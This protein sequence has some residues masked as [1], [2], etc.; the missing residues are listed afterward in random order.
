MPRN[1][2]VSGLKQEEAE[3]LERGR[4]MLEKELH[5]LGMS[6]ISRDDIA[7]LFKY[8]DVNSFCIAI[9]YGEISPNRIG[10]TLAARQEQPRIKEFSPESKRESSSVQVLGVGDLLTKL[11]NCCNPLPGDE[12]IGY[13]TRNRGITVH[14]KDCPNVSKTRE[15]DRLISVEWGEAHQTYPV[16]IRLEASDRVG[17]LRDVSTTI[18]EESVNIIG[19]GLS[20]KDNYD[21]NTVMFITLE[22]RGIT[23]LERVMSKLEGVKGV[24]SVGRS[25]G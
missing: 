11:S 6:S 23:Q 25:G 15:V 5:R 20:E 17:L 24:L 13:V 16:I 4:D 18:A 10:I 8:E 2:Y 19:M 21:G 14:R 7:T 9:G 22:A 3:N 1:R 12:I